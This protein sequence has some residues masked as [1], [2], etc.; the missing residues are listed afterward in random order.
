[1]SLLGQVEGA[2]SSTSARIKHWTNHS[3]LMRNFVSL[4]VLA[5]CRCFPLSLT[6]TPESAA[7]DITCNNHTRARANK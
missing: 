5:L 7:S 2:Q 6:T 1:M 4:S 3:D